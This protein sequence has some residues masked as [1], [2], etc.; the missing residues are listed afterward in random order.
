MVKEITHNLSENPFLSRSQNPQ[1]RLPN[2]LKQGKH[3]QTLCS[4]KAKIQDTTGREKE[5]KIS[6][7]VIHK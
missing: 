4:S 5:D 7:F 6:Y 2:L 1:S 3:L